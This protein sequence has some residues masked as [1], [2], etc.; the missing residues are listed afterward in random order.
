MDMGAELG[1]QLPVQAAPQTVHDVKIKR[2]VSTGRLRLE[3]MPTEE[4]LIPRD[5][6]AIDEE[7]EGIGRER[8]V[9]RS[10]LV[11]EGYKRSIVD[12]LP[13][14]ASDSEDTSNYARDR[15]KSTDGDMNRDKSME[16]VR[17]FEW[18]PLVDWD[19]DGV[20]ER[21]RVVIGDL[22]KDKQGGKVSR[23]ILLN[24]E[25][26]GDLPFTDIVPNPVAHRRRGRSAYDDTQDI[27]RVK[28]ALIRGLLNNT[29]QVNNPMQIAN[30]S[31]ISNP[32]ALNN[33]ELGATIWT[34]GDPNASVSAIVVP[35]VFDKLLPVLEYADLIKTGRTGVGRQTMGLDPDALQNQTAEAVRDGRAASETQ[36]EFYARNIAEIGLK[37]LFKCIL[38]IVISNQDK[39]KTIRLRNEWVDMDPRPWNSQM[40]CTVNVGLGAGSKDR[41]MVMLQAIAGKQEAIILNLGPE[42]PLVGFE[43]YRATLAEMV[44]TGGLRTADKYFKDVKPETIQMWQ[45]QQAQKPNP[46]MQKLQMEAQIKQ[47]E[48]QMKSQT[49]EKTLQLKA[50][51]E[52]VQAQADI[53]TN[54]RKTSADIALKEKEF[55]LKRELALLEAQLKMQQ[56][57]ASLQVEGQKM[58][59][60]AQSAEQDMHHKK[61]SHNM[62]M[63][64]KAM[65][66]KKDDAGNETEEVIPAEEARHAEVM[67][68]VSEGLNRLAD[69]LEKSEASAHEHRSKAWQEVQAMRQRRGL[70]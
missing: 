16:K 22:T 14:W 63:R 1:A 51:I 39:P 13:T 60:Q 59:M 61:Q 25:W 30:E 56:H 46:E 33:R 37:R 41:D 5:A 26:G 19:N 9:T 54:E 40:D 68:S 31:A 48:L 7:I 70:N 12:E 42:N 47:Q 67:K 45:Q 62:T 18:Y 15:L 11:K 8:N 50:Q 64:E 27:Q 35:P 43:E 4:L 23:K 6:T 2:T 36:V 20:A 34:R 52:Q 69:L 55:E 24:E 28:T 38:R 65:A 17:I 57:E 49:D 21:R 44:D 58:Q 66:A 29:Y 3:T 53:V 10:Q 32:E